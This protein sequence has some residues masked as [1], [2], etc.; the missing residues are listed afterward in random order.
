MFPTPTEQTTAVSTDLQAGAVLLAG[1]AVVTEAEVVG[2]LFT[3]SAAMLTLTST[4]VEVLAVL[5]V[6]IWTLA[7]LVLIAVDLTR[8]AHRRHMHQQHRT[9][10]RGL[11]HDRRRGGDDRA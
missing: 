3:A 11:T 5:G 9:G 4:A 10:H 6:A 2:L 1:P 7:L 8:A